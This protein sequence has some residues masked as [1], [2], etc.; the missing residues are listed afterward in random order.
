MANRTLSQELSDIRARIKHLQQK[1]TKKV[2]ISEYR[3]ALKDSISKLQQAD[4]A[5][6]E[7]ELEYAEYLK[8]NKISEAIK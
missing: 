7:A 3:I 2:G 5:M 8:V 6:L 4:M 1:I